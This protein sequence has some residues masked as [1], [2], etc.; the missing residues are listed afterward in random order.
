MSDRFIRF[1]PLTGF[2]ETVH[3]PGG[4]PDVQI[5]K[6]WAEFTDPGNPELIIP[7]RAYLRLTNLAADEIRYDYFGLLLLKHLDL[8]F[9]FHFEG[10]IP[11]QLLKARVKALSSL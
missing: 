8:S 1:A 10:D 5:E 11:N 6:G 9:F 2:R 7:V 4:D 3:G